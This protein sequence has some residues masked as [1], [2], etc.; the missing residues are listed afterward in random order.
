MAFQP[1]PCA[2]A[3]PSL[4]VQDCIC[5]EVGLDATASAAAAEAA[6]AGEERASSDSNGITTTLAPCARTP[7]PARFQMASR[8]VVRPTPS[9]AARVVSPGSLWPAPTRRS[10]PALKSIGCLLCER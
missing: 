9:W 6:V 8:T 2:S 10:H 1:D 4:H 5:A 3:Q 7:R